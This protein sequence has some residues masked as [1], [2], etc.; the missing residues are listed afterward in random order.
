MVL[1]NS[2]N[3]E[4]DVLEQEVLRVKGD[5]KLEEGEVTLVGLGKRLETAA[6]G[7]IA[8]ARAL[9]E[10]S[11]A[12]ELPAPVSMTEEEMR[13][14]YAQALEALLSEL[15]QPGVVG[16]D[17]TMASFRE[18]AVGEVANADRANEVVANAARYAARAARIVSQ[19]FGDLR[20]EIDDIEEDWARRFLSARN[21]D[22]SYREELLARKA[23]LQKAIGLQQEDELPPGWEPAEDLAQVDRQLVDVNMSLEHRVKREEQRK[24]DFATLDE[25]VAVIRETLA[26]WSDAQTALVELNTPRPF[27]PGARFPSG[28]GDDV[29]FYKFR[30]RL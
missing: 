1:H 4:L 8:A 21:Q 26:H 28:K 5:L 12:V 18:Q 25:M 15:G 13:Q 16:G 20:G 9:L 11:E 30:K 27:Q 14:T 2:L 6:A 29:T 23:Q 19:D 17:F 10:Y 22:E 7:P 24:Q 3:L